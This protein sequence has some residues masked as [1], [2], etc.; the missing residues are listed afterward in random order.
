MVCFPQ[1]HIEERYSV[2]QR[3]VIDA[4]AI[5]ST[6]GQRQTFR[7]PW[8]VTFPY[9][10]SPLYSVT[11]V[12]W[13]DDTHFVYSGTRKGEN[14]QYKINPFTGE[15][16]IIDGNIDWGAA[17]LS[18]DL[19]RAIYNNSLGLEAEWGL[20]DLVSNELI[21]HLGY[22]KFVPVLPSFIPFQWMPDSSGFFAELVG[23]VNND[24]TLLSSVVQFT[25]DGRLDQIIF[26]VESQMGFNF[27]VSSDGRYIALNNMGRLYLID[28]QGERVWDTCLGIQGMTWS[29]N[30]KQLAFTLNHDAVVF[31]IE[32]WQVHHVA[33]NVGAVV[34]WGTAD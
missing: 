12:R 34:A 7:V 23:L 2:S 14:Q 26:S 5:Y 30:G 24:N 11:S 3:F 32:T 31:E 16:E 15:N 20:Y 17:S 6:D 1:G 28:L 33:S 22:D 19:T 21:Q 9:G 18:G 29:P 25:R 4:I 8:E 27:Y 13:I 10:V